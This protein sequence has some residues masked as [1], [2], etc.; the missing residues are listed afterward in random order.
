MPEIQCEWCHHADSDHY[1][2]N[3]VD[4][5]KKADDFSLHHCH[6]CDKEHLALDAKYAEVK[7][8][9]KLWLAVIAAVVI[10]LV[11][12]WGVTKKPTGQC[13]DQQTGQVAPGD[14]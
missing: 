12:Y 3:G 14:C 7:H 4:G 11:V 1:R 10:A 9:K 13:F 5:F 8:R 2:V 6:I